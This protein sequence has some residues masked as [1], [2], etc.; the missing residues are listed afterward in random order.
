LSDDQSHPFL[1]TGETSSAL[2]FLPSKRDKL[3]T[4]F[5]P[6]NTRDKLGTDSSL[7]S[8]TSSALTT[9]NQGKV[10]LAASGRGA[11][12]FPNPLVQ[13]TPL[14]AQTPSGNWRELLGV[15]HGVSAQYM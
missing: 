7:A 8:E 2:T 5:S 14:S 12:C 13:H 11:T 15:L 3:S 1:V 6:C 10:A 4:A 9:D